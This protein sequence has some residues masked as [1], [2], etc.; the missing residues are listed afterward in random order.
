[1]NLQQLKEELWSL[2]RSDYLS[3]V[4]HQELY[5]ILQAIL[6]IAKILLYIKGT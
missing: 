1:M 6:L 5:P 4:G 2:E 3:Q